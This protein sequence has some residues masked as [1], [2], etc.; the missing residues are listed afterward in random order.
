MFTTQVVT[1]KVAIRANTESANTDCIGFSTDISWR[2]TRRIVL[3]SRHYNTVVV[4]VVVTATVAAVA[5]SRQS[6]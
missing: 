1:S 3:S 4:V 5:G 2:Q 6:R